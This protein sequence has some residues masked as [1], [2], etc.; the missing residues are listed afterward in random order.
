MGDPKVGGNN[1]FEAYDHAGP[2]FEQVKIEEAWARVYAA[3]Q[4][5]FAMEQAKEAA[6]NY[7]YCSSHSDEYC[8]IESMQSSYLIGQAGYPFWARYG[9]ECSPISTEDV[10]HREHMLMCY[11][12]ADSLD[13][14]AEVVRDEIP[15]LISAL[16]V[17]YTKGSQRTMPTQSVNEAAAE[18]LGLI[19][20]T[21]VG[22]LMEVLESSADQFVREGAATAL[23]FIASDS[24]GKDRSEILAALDS[25]ARNDVSRRVRNAA[26]N[27][28]AV[29]SP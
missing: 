13:I 21:A 15:A 9:C 20:A 14:F 1:P 23:G 24:S 26:A 12:A 18:T 19:G 28:I 6:Y 29:V 22:P 16:E 4:R 11:Y 8:E 25:S 27:A 10:E 7:N 2:S 17:Y 3:K 5:R